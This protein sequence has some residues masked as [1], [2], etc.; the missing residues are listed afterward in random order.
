M[1][2]KIISS[3][4]ALAMIVSCMSSPITVQAK[5]KPKLNKKSITIT[6]GDAQI[7]SLKK[8][9]KISKAKIKKVK[10]STSKKN[11]KLKVSG[12]YKTKCKIQT[13]KPGKTTVTLKYNGKKYKCKVTVKKRT[14][15]YMITYMLNGGTNN[16]ENATTYKNDTE[17]GLKAPTKTGYKFAGW[18]TNSNFTNQITKIN[19]NTNKNIT[20]YAK[21][22]KE[23]T[24]NQPSSSPSTPSNKPNNT[25]QPSTSDVPN[26]TE[27]P[28]TTEHPS[29]PTPTP[30]PTPTPAPS[31]SHTFGEWIIGTAAT[32][33]APGKLYRVCSECGETETTQIAATGHKF[34]KTAEV[35]VEATCTTPGRKAEKCLNPGCSAIRNEYIIPAK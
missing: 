1:K 33:T 3:I 22:V 26:T 11:V 25:T 6:V 12:K 8:Y 2:H 5:S 19:K 13:I 34:S 14:V 17:V 29:E 16:P 9:P 27:T 31:H 23:S 10:W 21:W 15:L 24:N 35:L 30:I 32:C 20:V 18:Y 28:N 4:L 7:I